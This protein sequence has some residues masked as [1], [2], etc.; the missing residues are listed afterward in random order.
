MEPLDVVPV[1][2]NERDIV[3]VLVR[4][5]G[6]GLLLQRQ[7]GLVAQR[8]KQGQVVAEVSGVQERAAQRHL[9]GHVD[10]IEV[11]PPDYR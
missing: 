10:F 3:K 8:R 7:F 11:C 4:R 6:V 1:C 2:P 9:R 5:A